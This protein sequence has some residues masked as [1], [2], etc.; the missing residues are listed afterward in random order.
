MARWTG[1]ELAYGAGIVQ[2]LPE[3]PLIGEM[4]AGKLQYYP[5]TTREASPHEG[6]ISD[7][8]R[9]GAVFSALGLPRWSAAEDRVMV[10]GNMALNKDIMSLCADAGLTE[11]V[12]RKPA[13]FVVEK[14]FVN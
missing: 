1:A 5:T 10:C 12:N 9:S 3:D 7:H 6:R 13:E 11:G 4:V 14:A 8:I 2:A